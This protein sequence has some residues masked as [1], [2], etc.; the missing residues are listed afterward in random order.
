MLRPPPLILALALAGAALPAAAP[1]QEYTQSFGQVVF[2]NRTDTTG[3]LWV[4][5]AYGC[6]PVLMNLFCVTQVEAGEH[7]AFVRFDDGEV[8]TFG[9]FYVE[10]GEIA[11]LTV[12][13]GPPPG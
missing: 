2:E 3:H 7:S 6:G 1:G 12:N 4:D 5:D 13:M 10:P 11:T 9:A 8:V